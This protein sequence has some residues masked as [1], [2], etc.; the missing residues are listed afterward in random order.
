MDDRLRVA[1]DHSAAAVQRITLATQNKRR[2]KTFSAGT[3]RR[4][5]M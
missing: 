1:L 3:A 5:T 2:V 4:S